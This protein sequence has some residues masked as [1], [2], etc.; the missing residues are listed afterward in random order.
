[1]KRLAEVDT[2]EANRQHQNRFHQPAKT[3]IMPYLVMNN[4]AALLCLV[5]AITDGD[6]LKA[7]CEDRPPITIRL[8]EIDA[9]ESKQPFGFRSKQSL[10]ELC[11]EKQAEVTPQTTDRWGR[12]VARVKCDRIDAS[13]EQIRRGM[14]WVFDKYVTDRR[15]YA[16]QDGARV[17]GAGLWADANPVPPWVWRKTH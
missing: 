9:P 15:L 17:N 2:L 1:M 4:P 16:V 3:F 14:A 10:A 13:A 11:H 5:I 7:R 6:T 8:A 12:T